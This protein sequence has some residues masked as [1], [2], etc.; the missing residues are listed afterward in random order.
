MFATTMA[1]GQIASTAPDV[2]KTV[3]GTATVPVPYPATGMPSGAMP[4]TKKVFI[5]NAPALTRMSKVTPTM[6]DQPGAS[7][8]GG[9]V[10]NAVMGPIEYL[11]ASPKVFLEGVPAVR[12]GDTVTMNNRNTVGVNGLPSQ[13][14]VMIG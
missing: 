3:V 5:V 6:G 14:K 10:S 4:V 12:L 7:G 1:G 13:T 11:S 2:C 9:V 8:G